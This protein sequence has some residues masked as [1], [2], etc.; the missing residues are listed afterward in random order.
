MPRTPSPKNLRVPRTRLP[1]CDSLTLIPPL[2]PCRRLQG[3]DGR[4]APRGGGGE[5]TPL[6]LQR[7]LPEPLDSI[8]G[9]ERVGGIMAT[10][11]PLLLT[12]A[13]RAPPPVDDLWPPTVRHPP[14]F[15]I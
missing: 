4:A 5:Q 8:P 10:R 12:E 9:G 7:V 15:M 2:P 14:S 3:P 11:S 1:P 6:H 13:G